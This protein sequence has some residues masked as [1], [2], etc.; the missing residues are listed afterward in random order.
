MT[1]GQEIDRLEKILKVVQ[2][3]PALKVD[4]AVSAINDLTT[5]TNALRSHLPHPDESKASNHAS[6]RHLRSP[7]TNVLRFD[8][9]HL[10][11]HDL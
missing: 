10:R 1:L 6:P 8:V 2:D 11:Q 3:D 9:A 5:A 4:A 7:L